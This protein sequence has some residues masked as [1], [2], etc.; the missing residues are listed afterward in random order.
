MPR[1]VPLV[2]LL[3]AVTAIGP[4]A[5]QALTPALPS[6]SG[7][8][9]VPTAV[10]QLMLS[11]SLVTTAFATLVWGPLSDRLGRRPMLVAGMA[12]AALG[13][14]AAALA[15]GIWPAILGRLVQAAGAAAGAVLARAV[16]Q[17]LYGRERASGVI[18][19]I[20]AVMVL[21]PMLAPVLSGLI[22]E[23]VGWRGVFALSGLAAL[24]LA[25]W[26]RLGLR[27][28]APPRAP[29]MPLAF[30]R[31]FAEVARVRAFWSHGCFGAA[32]LAAFLF[33]VGAAPY[34]MQEAY[35]AGPA[36]YGIAFIPLAAAYMLANMA[37]GW[38]TAHWGPRR[39]I[40][41]GSALTLGAMS[42]GL[43]AMALGFENPLGLMVPALC[44][45]IG[46][47]ISVPNAVAGAV[48]AAPERAGAASG[49]FGFLQFMAGAASA[50][51]AGFVPHGVAMP[52]VAG[53]AV[54]SAIGL[55][56]YVALEAKA[57]PAP[58]RRA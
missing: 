34:V 5:L 52:T 30:L 1:H 28:T 18:G 40:L 53:M 13:S 46:A 41:A 39:T 45:S 8:F 23:T 33:F 12:L 15:P 25:A 19:Q 58:A 36:V 55:A 42:V 22:V 9:R 38:V 11:L 20:T 21:A 17:D 24:V 37:C 29:D 16:A 14:G 51:V 56:G 10:T 32:S 35:G 48:G 50:Q 31:G 54:L 44:H 26:S 57:R 43:V 6:V 27:E 7:E 3:A 47:G 4:F 49:L 2:A